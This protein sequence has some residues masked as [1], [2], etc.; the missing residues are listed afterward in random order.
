MPD[1]KKFS[2]DELYNA[3]KRYT[4]VSGLLNGNL[5]FAQKMLTSF[6][7]HLTF[8]MDESLRQEVHKD[9]LKETDEINHSTNYLSNE[10]RGNIMRRI[11]KN[12]KKTEEKISQLLKL[13]KEA[14]DSRVARD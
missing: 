9:F 2:K 8:V 3:Y 6:D 10:L 1:L 5:E 13:L 14:G 12:I 4:Q 7:N 11:E